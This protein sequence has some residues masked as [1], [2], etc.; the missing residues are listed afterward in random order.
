MQEEYE[1]DDTTC[2]YRLSK[3]G[4]SDT[5]LMQQATNKRVLID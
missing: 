4:L 5:L 1:M 2:H 3:L